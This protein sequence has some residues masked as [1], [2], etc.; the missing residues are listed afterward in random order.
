MLLQLMP[1]R[2]AVC[3]QTQIISDEAWKLVDDIWDKRVQEIEEEV[4]IQ[5]EEATEKPQLLLVDHIL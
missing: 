2:V 4:S 5:I 1:A 3:V